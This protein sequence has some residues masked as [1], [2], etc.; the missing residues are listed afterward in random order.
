MLE[1]D[2]IDRLQTL[3]HTRACLTE[4]GGAEK[5]IDG[6]VAEMQKLLDLSEARDNKSGGRTQG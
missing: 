2:E 1:P 5:V 3:A 6:I 4:H